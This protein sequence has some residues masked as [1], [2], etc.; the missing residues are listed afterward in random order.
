MPDNEQLQMAMAKI[1]IFSGPAEFRAWLKTNHT[2]AAEL[3][4]GIYNRRAD[5]TSITYREAL[6][7]A[8]CFG[9]IDGVRGSL[10]DITYTI[11]FS[12]RKAGSYWST[13]NTKRFGELKKLR[14]LTPAGLKAFENRSQESGKYSFENRPN[15]LDPALEKQ[16]RANRKAWEFFSAQATWYRRT[17][18]F[19]VASA[20]KEE[21]RLKRLATLMK[22]SEAGQRI[23]LLA[24]KEK[25]RHGN[26]P[27]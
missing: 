10:D 9:W 20:K 14:R 13:V 21:T 15:Q 12:P 11:R 18:I 4:L 22:D 7:E 3:V 1:K 24:R 19:W 5:K 27:P 23:G 26:S 16:F 6:D 25:K 2:K 17:S 8:L